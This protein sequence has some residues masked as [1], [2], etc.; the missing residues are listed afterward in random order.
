MGHRPVVRIARESGCKQRR[1]EPL[2]LR[3]ESRVGIR[4]REVV[5]Q[6]IDC[7]SV[8]HAVLIADLQQS[9]CRFPQRRRMQGFTAQQQPRPFELMSG[10]YDAAGEPGCRLPFR[11]IGLAERATLLAD[12]ARE[13]ELD[14]PSNPCRP[15]GIVTD[16]GP[17]QAG[18]EQVH[19]RV[20]FASR[21]CC[22]V[23]G[24]Q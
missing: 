23:R 7:H 6:L 19:V 20:G 1:L 16:L 17:S 24:T 13:G 4:D 11:G 8:V 3:P 15:S 22:I 9:Q 12:E 14:Q 10:F 5:K 2:S 18:L 21:G